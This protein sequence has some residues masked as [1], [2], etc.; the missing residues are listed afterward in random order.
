MVEPLSWLRVA[1]M[2][3]PR[4]SPGMTVGVGRGMTG[5][6]PRYD[7]GGER[8]G[9]ASRVVAERQKVWAEWSWVGQ[10]L[11]M[12]NRRERNGN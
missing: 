10:R 11:L 4:S 6:E 5:G 1:T 7:R 3:I 8:R 2:W 9:M 12:Q